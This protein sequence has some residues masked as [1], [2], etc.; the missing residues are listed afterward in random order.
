MK[1]QGDITWAYVEWHQIDSRYLSTRSSHM[2]AV[3]HHIL[4]IQIK[5][6]PGITLPLKIIKTYLL[7][8]TKE[9][10][11]CRTGPSDWHVSA[12][13]NVVVDRALV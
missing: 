7:L 4:T 9:A 6:V 13:V 5:L 12:R 8:T 2:L 11:S 10:C 3:E 1:K